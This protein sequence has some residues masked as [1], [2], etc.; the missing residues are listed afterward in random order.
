LHAPG[1]TMK[2]F[3]RTNLQASASLGKFDFFT[4]CSS[5]FC[6]FSFTFR[7]IT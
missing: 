4:L 7:K 5:C 1:R 3:C 6:N 2:R